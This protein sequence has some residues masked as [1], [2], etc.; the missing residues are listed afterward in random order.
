MIVPLSF[1]VTFAVKVPFPSNSKR[2]ITARGVPAEWHT[3]LTLAGDSSGAGA[4]VREYRRAASTQSSGRRPTPTSAALS[5][6]TRAGQFVP[7][8]EFA[9]VRLRLNQKDEALRW[10]ANACDERSLFVLFLNVDPLYDELRPNPR[11]QEL[12]RCIQ[13][14]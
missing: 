5:K 14:P 9:R 7:A 3:S 6:V 13:V 2:S 12:A 10:L 8:M 1:I 4:V 11:F